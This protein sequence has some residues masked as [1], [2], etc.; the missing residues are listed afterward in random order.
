MA[1]V[2]DDLS[3]DQLEEYQEIFALFDSDGKGY[4]T[5]IKL[6]QVM[7]HFGWDPSESILQVNELIWYTSN[8][9][10]KRE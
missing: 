5:L 8:F 7:R 10:H 4:I 3:K 1:E 6:G 9:T 2:L